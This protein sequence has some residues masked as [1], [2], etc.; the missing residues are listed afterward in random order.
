M[1][2][3]LPIYRE[4]GRTYEPDRCQEVTAAAADGKVR[5]EGLG[6][7]RYPGHRL[8]ADVLAGVRSVG[9][10]D[11][12]RDQDWGVQWHYNEGLELSLLERGRLAFSLEQ[13][14]FWLHPN[15]LTIT[16]PWQP[17]R[18]GDPCLTA[19]RLH[20][21]ILD[22]G[23]RRPH[24][25]W[26]WPPWVLLTKSD[27]DQLTTVLRHN[28]QP[29]WRASARTRLCFQRIAHAVERYRNGNTLSRLA[30]CLNEL[31][32][33][34]L[35][36]FR[37]GGLD[38]D[39]SLS[40]VRRTVEL[41]LADLAR[42]RD[43]LAVKWTTEKMAEQCALGARSFAQCC[44]ELTNLTPGQYLNHCRLAA[45]AGLLREDADLSVTQIAMALG[46]S[47]SQYFATLFAREFGESPRQYRGRNGP[48]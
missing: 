40:S 6:R 47:S 32:V 22:V 33:L 19:S 21:F 15:D 28:E 43:Q 29:V 26:Q 46:F 41:F 45:A 31:L 12:P 23:V 1:S 20:W 37:H 25:A 39:Q 2:K 7:G 4:Q 38:L 9:F 11:T 13:Q 36:M 8:P 35:E 18:L 24:Q 17:H 3:S 16:R 27:R 30:I 34:L 5:L 44:R 48:P 14:R 42:N 10:L